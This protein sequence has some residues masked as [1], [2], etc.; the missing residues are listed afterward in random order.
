V[1]SLEVS[2]SITIDR[3]AD[4]VRRQFA[5]V[6][7][8]QAAGV[9]RGVRF[10]VLDD[11]GQRCRYRQ[12]SRAG[13]LKLTQEFELPRSDEGPLVNSIT[14]GQF[15]GGKISFVVAPVSSGQSTVQATVVSQV[16]GVESLLLPLLRLIVRRT[17][18]RA[19]AE[20][21]ADLEGGY[22]A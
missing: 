6:A 10:E 2:E 8:H 22:P 9:H 4:V 1:R 13:P 21:K 15:R 11:D 17:L 14:R 16:S 5:D 3:S 20:D 7:H 19:L 18:A 12:V